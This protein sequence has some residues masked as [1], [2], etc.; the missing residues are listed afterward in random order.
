MSTDVLH[1]SD[2]WQ[3][4]AL[5]EEH[6]PQAS[7]QNVGTLE[8]W[9]ALVGGGGLAIYGLTTRSWGGLAASLA[10]GL[11]A[12]RGWT[13]YC[14]VYRAAGINTAV[15]HNERR[16][17]KAQQGVKIERSLHIEREPQELYDFW[18]NL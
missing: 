13:G 8:R 3:S 16:G 6:H 4:D 1:P 15:H 2:A 18:R 7:P 17:V 9:L 10:G 14:P 11:L 5:Y 12:Y